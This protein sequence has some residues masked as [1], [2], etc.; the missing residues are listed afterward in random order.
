MCVV[1]RK[2]RKG[3]GKTKG[4]RGFM[5][6]ERGA[7]WEEQG[8]LLKSPSSARAPFPFCGE[9]VVVRPP[10]Q[11][12]CSSCLP[13]CGRAAFGAYVMGGGWVA[14]PLCFVA[15]GWARCVGRKDVENYP[16]KK[17]F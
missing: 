11:K 17:L 6:G 16:P 7:I 5:S 9:G 1:C 8:I 4:G 10:P 15:R 14:K 3:G 12:H 2:Q 13:L